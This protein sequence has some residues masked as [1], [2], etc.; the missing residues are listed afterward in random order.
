[1]LIIE[2]PRI[3]TEKIITN[4]LV[5]IAPDNKFKWLGRVDN[6]INSGGVKLFPE[7]IESKLATKISALFFVCGILDSVLG[8]TV[9][10]VMEAEQYKLDHSIFEDLDKYEK[11]KEVFFIPQFTLT[12]NGKIKRKEI[13]TQLN[14]F[15]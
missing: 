6:V 2:A 7:V 14:S 11:P 9:V 3:S 15:L 1:C 5:E 12:E 10:L 13:L 8:E 4:D